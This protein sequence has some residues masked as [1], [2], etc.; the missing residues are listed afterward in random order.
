MAAASISVTARC[1]DSLEE[2]CAQGPRPIHV[3]PLQLSLARQDYQSQ[4]GTSRTVLRPRRY[5]SRV[6][7]TAWDGLGQSVGGHPLRHP[8]L[9]HIVHLSPFGPEVPLLQLQIYPS[10]LVSSMT[11]A[12]DVS[13]ACSTLPPS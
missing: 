4:R 6:C 9:S 5:K 12:W 8:P 7:G 13:Y 10:S 2:S 3:L 11:S 1:L